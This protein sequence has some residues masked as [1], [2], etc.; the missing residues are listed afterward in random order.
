MD[1]SMMHIWPPK[2]HF[3]HH[4]PSPVLPPPPPAPAHAWP[5]SPPSPPDASYWHHP[6][7]DRLEKPSESTVSTIV[8]LAEEAKMARE[9]VVKALKLAF[10][11]VYKSLVTGGVAGGV[12]RT[13]VAPLE[14]LKILL[15]VHFFNLFIPA[16]GANPNPHHYLKAGKFLGLLLDQMTRREKLKASRIQ[17]EAREH[18]DDVV[19]AQG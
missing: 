6:L 7:S 5:P 8:N 10:L 11:S 9:G 19:V 16:H 15:Q 17:R 1:Q 4:F 18:V 3:P 2:H 13:A 12:S 14:R